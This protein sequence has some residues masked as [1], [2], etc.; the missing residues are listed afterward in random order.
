MLRGADLLS[1]GLAFC[2]KIKQKCICDDNVSDSDTFVTNSAVLQN[3]DKISDEGWGIFTRIHVVIGRLLPRRHSGVVFLPTGVSL[4]ARLRYEQCPRCP[5]G[6]RAP[7]SD[8]SS[9]GMG[10]FSGQRRFPAYV[11][12]DDEKRAAD[13]LSSRDVSRFCRSVFP[14]RR[15][16][17]LPSD[18]AFFGHEALPR[19]WV[20][21]LT[22]DVLPKTCRPLSLCVALLFR[23]APRL[24]SSPAGAPPACCG[25]SFVFSAPGD[26]S[27]LRFA[28]DRSSSLFPGARG[29]P[30]AFSCAPSPLSFFRA[31]TPAW[32]CITAGVLLGL[33]P[34]SRAPSALRTAFAQGFSVFAA[35]SAGR[36]T[37]LVRA[38]GSEL[39]L[40]PK[41][42]FEQTAF[43]PATVASTELLRRGRTPF[44]APGAENA[45]RVPEFF[46]SD[47][48]LGALVRL[49]L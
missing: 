26:A 15:S 23:A 29:L 44:C 18:E 34:A 30:Y 7:G 3:G 40:S 8:A 33:R 17:V 13:R 39:L 48:V 38:L 43:A 19:L 5:L 9:S 46:P 36:E 4:L 20:L 49:F 1:W 27:L 32:S 37:V 47:S 31:W 10:K 14:V 35:A 6:R 25:A 41:I 42:S 24:P 2:K 45:L 22:G 28:R 21:F 12:V 11:A 16:A